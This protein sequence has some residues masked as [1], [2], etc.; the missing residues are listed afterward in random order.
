MAD[1]LLCRA[2]ANLANGPHQGQ[3]VW[4]DPAAEAMRPFLDRG[5]LVPV[6]A[7][8]GREAPVMPRLGAV[9]RSHERVDDAE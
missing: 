2:T 4:I 5:L 7:G 6:D 1:P 3:I 8:D 9:D